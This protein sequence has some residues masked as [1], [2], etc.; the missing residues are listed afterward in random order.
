M[1]TTVLGGRERWGQRLVDYPPERAERYRR[2]GAW[3]DT[4]LAQ[5]LHEIAARFPERPAVVTAAASVTYAELDRATDRIAV[6]LDALGLRPGDPVLFQ[7]TNR[8]ET[9]YAWYGCLKAGLVPVATL[10]AHR[11]HEIGHISRK[12]G[13]V[14]HLVETGLSFDLVA[15]ARDQ[16]QGHPTLRHILTVGD[17][18]GAVAIESLGA[19]IPPE[20]ARAH[21]ERVQAGI[22]PLD[23]VAFQLSG[24]TTGVPKVIPRRH[25]EYWNNALYYARRL[26][27]TEHTRVAHLIPLIHNAGI[28]CA[29]HGAHSVGACLVLATPDTATAFPLLARARATDVLIG[30]G[31]Y[32]A[33][34]SPGFDAARVHLRRV[35]LSGAKLTDELFA[36]ADDGAG[37][38]AGQLFGMSEGLF[39][40]TPPDA[41]A[42]AR[43]TTVGTPIAPD[44]E[45]RI[46]EP[47][48][49]TEL[50]DGTVGELCCRG[51]YTI[52][53]YFDAPE[54]NRSAFTPDG[55]YRTGDLARI[56]VI[57]GVRYVSIE[58]RIKDL[59]NRGGE[60]INA[61]EVELLLVRHPNVANAAVVAMPDPRL[62]EKTC[63][64][65][66]AATGVASSLD[67]IRAHLEALGVAKFKWPERLEWVQE[68]PQTSVGKVDKKRL[69]TD[70]GEKLASESARPGNQE[71]S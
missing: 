49:D 70:I 16:A 1:R 21:V 42:L 28:T 10:A 12:V 64:Y 59:I 30:H 6:G 33:V 3:T 37:H 11:A 24:G 43:A 68:L 66:V 2:S 71:H 40:V 22:D 63:A 26:G 53:G 39:T 36:R 67:D 25:V 47:G 44:D 13:A 9:V 15:F 23:V 14:A 35:V 61:E 19:G 38:W 57:D 8:L 18:A 65:L 41:P 62:G 54:H 48:A 69:R 46:L 20:P 45:V 5:R 51:P 55:F 17:P 4:P 34:L 7:A 52:P 60:K 29:L 27:W 50:P 31:H 56:V 32:Q 58:G